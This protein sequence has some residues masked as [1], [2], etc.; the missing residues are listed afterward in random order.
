MNWEVA[1][2]ELLDYGRVPVAAPICA[3]IDGVVQVGS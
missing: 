3:D 2:S 1:A